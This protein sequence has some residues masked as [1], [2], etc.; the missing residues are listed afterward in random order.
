[1]RWAAL[2]LILLAGWG[3]VGING[4]APPPTNAV[5]SVQSSGYSAAAATPSATIGT[6]STTCLSGCGSTTYTLVS[7]S[8]YASQACQST[9]FAI[10]GTTLSA[11]ASGDALGT[12]YPCVQ[13]ASAAGTFV[14]RM[15]VQIGTSPISVGAQVFGDD[16]ALQTGQ[17][18][19]IYPALGGAEN[20]KG[21]TNRAIAGSKACDA[22]SAQ[23]INASTP[24][25]ATSG[26]PLWIF[27]F[28]GVEASTIGTGA[29][30]AAFKG[31]LGAGIS[32]VLTPNKILG[33]SGTQG[34]SGWGSDSGPT[35]VFV[36]SASAGATLTFTIT[37]SA[38][39]PNAYNTNS[40]G[41]SPAT[42][43]YCTGVVHVL[44]KNFSGG[45]TGSFTYAVDGGSPVTVTPYSDAGATRGYSLLRIPNLSNTS[46]SIVLTVGTNTQAL[47]FG[48]VWTA[49]TTYSGKALVLG[50][51]KEQSDANSAATAAYDKDIA[52]EVNQM[53][54]DELDVLFVPVRSYVNVANMVGL[55][56]TATGHIQIA[57]A[58]QG[59][60]PLCKDVLNSLP[61]PSYVVSQL[62]GVAT[63]LAFDEEGTSLSTV[64]TTNSGA[65]GFNWYLNGVWPRAG[66][67]T[68]WRNAAC[69]GVYPP[70]PASWVTQGAG[71]IT[72]SPACTPSGSSLATMSS[73]GVPSNSPTSPPYMVGTPLGGGKGWYL[74]DKTSF[75]GSGQYVSWVSSRGFLDQA[76]GTS[77]TPSGWFPEVD[78]PDQGFGQNDVV[79]WVMT[80]NAGSSLGQFG[81]AGSGL[82]PVSGAAD[83]ISV[84]S[85]LLFAG[86]ATTFYRNGTQGVSGN[87]D[88]GIIA[89]LS[90]LCLLESDS[91]LGT[92]TM[93]YRRF[94]QQPI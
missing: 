66:Q 13:S 91:S 92:I 94:W 8:D 28:G 36:A 41:T 52:D 64:D 4:S 72:L 69:G 61:L 80:P 86:G 37:P 48:G 16:V 21:L 25:V 2:L 31:C 60:I 68:G 56:P 50:V 26:N 35:G 11:N 53:A 40:C 34:G 9:D 57:Q 38:S 87:E 17:S 73:C 39:V 45:N 10:S 23:I 62:Q 55:I 90:Q 22:V 44:Y 19:P 75:T 47:S 42:G 29:Y 65:P 43:N 5:L 33:S 63:C 58:L 89:S 83:G 1:M 18:Y 78:N 14:Q 70:L 30:E 77:F 84:L 82:S 15:T 27:E 51:L 54:N 59:Q 49:P 12:Y 88:A 81:G 32:W 6:L 3:R 74:E 93:R 85:P 67:I 20:G 46:H 71:G 76:T 7:G 24:S 79:A